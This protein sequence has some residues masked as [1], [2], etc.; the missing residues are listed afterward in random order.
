[1]TT[2]LMRDQVWL[3]SIQEKLREEAHGGASSPFGFQAQIVNRITESSTSKQRQPLTWT[4]LKHSIYPTTDPTRPIRRRISNGHASI[5]LMFLCIAR[6]NSN[7]RLDIWIRQRVSGE[8]HCLIHGDWQ[9]IGRKEWLFVF[10]WVVVCGSDETSMQNREYMPASYLCYCMHPYLWS[11]AESTQE[12]GR[13]HHLD[14]PNSGLVQYPIYTVFVNV[15]FLDQFIHLSFDDVLVA[16]CSSL[17]R[18]QTQPL[19]LKDSFFAARIPY[20][21]VSL[22]PLMRC[23]QSMS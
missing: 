11:D 1:M 13:S 8:T 19:S 5:H 20:S 21:R 7:D 9:G 3:R 14:N 15:E 4:T 16:Q 22:L 10:V 17:Y 23:K 18:W 12:R 2:C 6:L